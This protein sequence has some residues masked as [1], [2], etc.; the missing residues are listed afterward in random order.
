ML[1]ANGVQIPWPRQP[2]DCTRSQPALTTTTTICSG[3]FAPD[4]LALSPGDLVEPVPR[5]ASFSAA[6]ASVNPVHLHSKAAQYGRFAIT[7]YLHGPLICDPAAD[8]FGRDY[9]TVR[10]LVVLSGTAILRHGAPH[11]AGPTAQRRH[12][13][14]AHDGA[15][16]LG[17]HPVGYETRVPTQ[18]IAIDLPADHVAGLIHHEMEPV[19]AGCRSGALLSALGAFAH[20][21]LYHE[22]RT[23]KAAVY[24]QIAEMLDFVCMRAIAT[25][26]FPS[27]SDWSPDMQR[28]YVERYIAARYADPHL[29][30][31]SVAA[32]LGVST[33]SLYRLFQGTG[34]TLSRTID[35]RRLHRALTRLRD[36]RYAHLTVAEIARL[37]GFKSVDGLR[38]AVRAATG[39]TP[40]QVRTQALGAPASRSSDQLAHARPQPVHL[41]H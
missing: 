14:G 37:S 19:A 18:I 11:D 28:E 23:P 7:E 31:A 36:A 20:E 15:I 22:E 33:R 12:E 35:A 5:F 24:E 26:V 13:L 25:H 8:N 16:V 21:L 1:V 6:T 27:G 40:N 9:E 17:W 30:A 32:H 10:L 3:Q 38:R 2:S 4:H 39:I 34:P 41:D 29:N